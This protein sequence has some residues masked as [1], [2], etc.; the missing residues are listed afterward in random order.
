[1]DSFNC[2]YHPLTTANFYCPQCEFNVCNTCSDENDLRTNY[3]DS[4]LCVLCQSPLEQLEH[5]TDIEPFWHNLKA[6]YLYP[7]TKASIV[8]SLLASVVASMTNSFFLFSLFAVLIIT[9][10]S[11]LCLEKTANGEL[12]AADF[13]DIFDINASSRSA[14]GLFGVLICIYTIVSISSKLFGSGFA[15]LVYIFFSFS[16]PASVISLAIDKKVFRAIDPLNLL[17]I[18]ATTGKSYLIMIVFLFIMT[19]SQSLINSYLFSESLSSVA[20]FINFL[21]ICYYTTIMFHIMGHIVY[22]NR[23]TIAFSIDDKKLDFEIREPKKQQQDNIETL[24]K[25]GYYGKAASLSVSSLDKT[26]S[27]LWS[28][29]QS[30]NLVL[31]SREDK[32]V[33]DFF[34]TYFDT[35]YE[36]NEYDLLADSYLNAKKRLPTFRPKNHNVWLST[37]QSLMEIGHYKK[38]ASLISDFDKNCQDRPLIIDAYQLISDCLNKIPGYE[39]KAQQYGKMAM[40]LKA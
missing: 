33:S 18:I 17:S 14:A 25:A 5:A 8:M 37:A 20:I 11:F 23:H 36:K 29:K 9:Y 7:L 40:A 26:N 24:I 12:Q 3:S 38:A 2:K 16:F 6:I 28:W 22:Q 31:L 32:K 34:N 21:V 10:Y 27:S 35:L 4:L 19:S 39:N 30:F 13:D 1:M 15:T